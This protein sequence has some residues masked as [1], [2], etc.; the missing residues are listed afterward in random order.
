MN[1]TGLWSRMAD[2]SRP[3]ASAGVEGM[4]TLSP[5]TWQTHA[6]RLCECCSAAPVPEPP[7]VRST[8]GTETWPPNW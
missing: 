7:G 3:L 5:G 1:T 2:F 6:S 8:M 4:T